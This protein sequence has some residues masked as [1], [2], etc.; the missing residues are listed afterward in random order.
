LRRDDSPTAGTIELENASPDVIEIETDRHPLQYL[1][2][3]VTD[4]EGNLLSE[5]HYGDTFSPQGSIT[6]FQLP[7]GATYQHVVSLFATVP[8]AKRSSGRYSIQAVF[9]YDGLEVASEPLVVELRGD[10]GR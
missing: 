8:E 3:V 9:D 6:A 5:R 2:L 4:G 1:N 7:P 10:G